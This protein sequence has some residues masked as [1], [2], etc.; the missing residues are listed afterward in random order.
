MISL[1]CTRIVNFPFILQ[2][3]GI[4]DHPVKGEC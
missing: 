1:Y 2:T 4:R 3:R